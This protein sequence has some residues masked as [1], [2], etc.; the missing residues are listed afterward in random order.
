MT[1]PSRVNTGRTCNSCGGLLAANG[2]YCEFCG[3]S[4]TKHS[5][6][7]VPDR[8]PSWPPP[9]VESHNG[10]PSSLAPQAA[11][12]RSHDPL[13]HDASAN[14]AYIGNR[15]GYTDQG[16]NFDPLSNVTYHQ[17]LN[18]KF[19]TI[20]IAWLLGSL[21]LGILSITVSVIAIAFGESSGE[22]YAEVLSGA[23]GGVLIVGS[24]VWSIFSVLLACMFWFTR[25][26]VQLSEW[27]LTVD[28]QGS[29][30]DA[31]LEH[32][33]AII[34]ARQTPIRSLRVVRL[35]P[36]GQQV[37]SYLRLDDS[38][39]TGFVSSFAYGTDL[40]IGWIFWLDLSPAGWLTLSLRRMFGGAGKGIYGSL[41][42][43]RPKAMREVMHAAVRQ[44]VDMANGE[45]AP[46]GQ[47]DRGIPVTNVS[48]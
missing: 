42:H 4:V 18:G 21:V 31:A 36:A 17:L 38:F 14:V 26:P 28:G 48:L 39:F 33:C 1:S 2:R 3:A 12:A 16:T 30:A 5:T 35:M 32:M 27:M 22:S 37:R 46:I 20:L 19:F 11:T 10:Q 15:L 13:E 40:Y 6:S 29:A 8:L 25:I 7:P 47:G 41:I 9:L 24:V 45:V 23:L 34:S 44:G 43:D